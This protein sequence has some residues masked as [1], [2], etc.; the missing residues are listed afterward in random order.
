MSSKDVFKSGETGGRRAAIRD[1]FQQPNQELMPS[2]LPL[3]KPTRDIN[4]S[5]R[6]HSIIHQEGPISYS[7]RRI[8]DRDAEEFEYQRQANIVYNKQFKS[9]AKLLGNEGMDFDE[10]KQKVEILISQ[11]SSKRSESDLRH[12]IQILQREM[13]RKEEK[14]STH[15]LGTDYLKTMEA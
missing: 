6:S 12:K 3:P 1:V 8:V 4:S 9:L 2:Q 10:L 15:S 7:D 11:E 5:N 14:R 13:N